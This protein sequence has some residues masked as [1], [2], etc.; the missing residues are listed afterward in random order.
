MVL[1]S[2]SLGVTGS[3]RGASGVVLEET[4]SSSMMRAVLPASFPTTNVFL[5][6][7]ILRL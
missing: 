6:E 5:I 3:C 1:A 4:A 7:R 2:G